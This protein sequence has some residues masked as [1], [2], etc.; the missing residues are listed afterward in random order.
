VIVLPATM[1]S[2]VRLAVVLFAATLHV[3]APFPLPLAP[4]V[5]VIHGSAIHGSGQDGSLPAIPKLELEPRRSRYWPA[6]ACAMALI[7]IAVLARKKFLHAQT[8]ESQRSISGLSDFRCVPLFG[9]DGTH[10]ADVE[11]TPETNRKQ[12]ELS[13]P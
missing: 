11:R 5:S 1:M 7:V 13:R 10:H 2:P 8:I 12:R 4:L 9:V 6:L 3:V